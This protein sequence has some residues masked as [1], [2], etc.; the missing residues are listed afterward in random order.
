MKSNEFDED[1]R[2]FK[3][4][5]LNQLSFSYFVC[6]SQD[7]EDMKKRLFSKCTLSHYFGVEMKRFCAE[8][9]FVESIPF[10]Q[11]ALK[12]NDQRN[13]GG[14]ETNIFHQVSG[15]RGFRTKDR[16]N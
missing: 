7:S 12:L 6:P 11:V 8:L 3:L 5:K 1:M 16:Q 13:K 2:K 10:E 14:K 4:S 15:L 9:D